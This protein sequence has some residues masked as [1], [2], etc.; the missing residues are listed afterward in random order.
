MKTTV[1]IDLT[2]DASEEAKICLNCERKKCT[3]DHCRR[4]EQKMKE[5]KQREKKK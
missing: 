4:L 2:I 1:S 3:P 5:M